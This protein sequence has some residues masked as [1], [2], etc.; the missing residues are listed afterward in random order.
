MSDKRMTSDHTREQVKLDIK[1]SELRNGL[2][3]RQCIFILEKLVGL[4]HKNA[5]LSAG[6]SLSV[7]ENSK[8]RILND[9]LN[10]EFE[11][12]KSEVASRIPRK[13]EDSDDTK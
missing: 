9:R 1:R 8:Q 6:Y 5:A 4:N 7:S 2:T 13:I 10:A 12:L 11:R 3:K